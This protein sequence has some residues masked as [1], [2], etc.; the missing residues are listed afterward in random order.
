M[1]KLIVTQNNELV[2]IKDLQIE[3]FEQKVNNIFDKF[4][5]LDNSTNPLKRIIQLN[6]VLDKCCDDDYYFD[7]VEPNVIEIIDCEGKVIR[8]ESVKLT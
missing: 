6:N 2:C 8:V 4:D 3:K 7:L 1:R 5:E